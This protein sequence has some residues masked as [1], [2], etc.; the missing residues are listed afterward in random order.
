MRSHLIRWA[1][2]DD[3][4][5]SHNGK[6]GST[7]KSFYNLKTEIFDEKRAK[8]VNRHTLKHTA[9]TWFLRD[10]VSLRIV[11]NYLSTTEEVI[12]RVYGKHHPGWHAEIDAAMRGAR[13][14]RNKSRKAAE[15][16]AAKKAA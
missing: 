14:G 5:I 4:L 1:K 6:V 9:A 7:K 2:E 8:K 13:E 10:G 12:E 16:K 3:D 15:A 11:A